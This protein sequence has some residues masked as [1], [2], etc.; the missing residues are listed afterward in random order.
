MLSV[1]ARCR[2]GFGR[3]CRIAIARISELIVA[4][5]D[6]CGR[7]DRIMCYEIVGTTGDQWGYGA[8][9]VCGCGWQERRPK[10]KPAYMNRYCTRN[11]MMRSRF[12]LKILDNSRGEK[13]SRE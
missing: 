7:W 3:R 9:I 13:N 12:T 1:A 6:Y 2:V 4:P 11:A 5:G 8:I 10:S